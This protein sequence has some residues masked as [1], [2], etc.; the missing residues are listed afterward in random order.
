M[1]RGRDGVLDEAREVNFADEWVL[2][3]E[4]DAV[5][6]LYAGG[7]GERSLLATRSRPPP[8][9]QSEMI[10]EQLVLSAQITMM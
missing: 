3:G 10:C 7:G 6:K 9:A 2:A 1:E 4:K 8:V 5:G